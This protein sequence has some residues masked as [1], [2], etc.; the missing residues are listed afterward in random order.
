MV[1]GL[2]LAAALM[3]TISSAVYYCFI[4]VSA[5]DLDG[6]ATVKGTY[7]NSRDKR[8]E[9]VHVRVEGTDISDMTD[10]RGRYKL[11]PVPAGRQKIVFERG[12]YPTMTIT[13]LIIPEDR[14]ERYDV[15]TNRLDVPDNIVGGKLVDKPKF[16]F[17]L[18]EIPLESSNLTG[19]LAANGISFK[20]IAITVHNATANATVNGEGYFHLTDL[21]PGIL[22]LN[23]THGEYTTHAAAFLKEGDNNI[24]FWPVGDNIQP[25][26][27]ENDIDSG[28]AGPLTVPSVED[29]DNW[30][31]YTSKEEIR[32]NVR[33][34]GK[35][36]SDTILLLKPLPYNPINR[37]IVNALAHSAL[38]SHVY[39]IRE[40]PTLTMIEGAV[41]GLEV[42]APGLESHFHWNLTYNGTDTLD[43]TLAGDIEPVSYSYSL[44][45]FKIII[46][47]QI[48]LS[49]IISLCIG[50]AFRSTNFSRVMTG[51]IAAF[52]S[53]ASLPLAFL[54]MSLA[55]NWI[56]GALA[57]ILLLIKRKYFSK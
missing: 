42:A 56:L 28:T 53:S 22:L 57:F 3:I 12:G 50:S 33:S 13:Q 18:N 5:D 45:G 34:D 30:T 9:G 43:I 35:T 27:N 16:S 8:V 19:K 7:Y 21:Y 10:D 46:A 4:V 1:I 11:E 14:L 29:I 38:E 23:V 49:V 36:M 25:L 39:N 51:A 37:T 15:E 32:V 6:T 17:D 2:L 24:T 54:A 20:D 26:P 31:Y 44:L 47:F 55:H 52:V 40:R 41:Y 48:F